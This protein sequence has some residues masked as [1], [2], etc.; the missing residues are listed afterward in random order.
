MFLQN[1]RDPVIFYNFG[2]IFLLKKRLNRSMDLYIES[3]V[4]RSTRS[5]ASLNE[6]RPSV[7][8]RPRLE[9]RRGMFMF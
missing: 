2:F 3:T 5:M 4:L 6:S 9:D 8:L 1:S 7:D